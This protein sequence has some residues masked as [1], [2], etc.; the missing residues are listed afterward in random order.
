MNT[1]VGNHQ[2][3]C[4]VIAGDSSI[5]EKF[6]IINVKFSNP[7]TYQKIGTAPLFYQEPPTSPRAIGAPSR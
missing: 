3:R 6:Q 5:I 1:Q 4:V 7:M 2:S